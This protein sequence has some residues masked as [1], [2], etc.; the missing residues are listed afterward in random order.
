MNYKKKNHFPYS[1]SCTSI[2]VSLYV[3]SVLSHFSR[4]WLFATPWTVACQAS[5]SMGFSRQE[6]WSGLL[7]P[8]PGDLPDPG[9]ELTSLTSPASVGGFFTI[10]TTWEALTCSKFIFKF[11]LKSWLFFFFFLQW[12]VAELYFPCSVSPN[13]FLR[14]NCRNLIYSL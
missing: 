6:Y 12:L 2:N 11:Y 10:S 3:W 8:S 1:R 7:C 13:G 4:V 14:F 9:I 5:L